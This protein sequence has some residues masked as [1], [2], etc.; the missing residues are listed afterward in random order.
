ME[1][2]LVGSI[3]QRAFHMSHTGVYG[4]DMSLR[5]DKGRYDVTVHQIQ[6]D[7]RGTRRVKELFIAGTR[8]VFATGQESMSE[9]TFID[10]G[11][12]G[13]L[14]KEVDEEWQNWLDYKAGKLPRPCF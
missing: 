8:R 3:A 1:N 10:K 2:T 14:L 12:E 13:A 11:I 5:L 4:I 7:E 6:K 9:Y